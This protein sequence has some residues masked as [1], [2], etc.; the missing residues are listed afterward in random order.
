[1]ESLEDHKSQKVRKSLEVFKSQRRLPGL[2][3]LE[4]QDS[5]RL[6]DHKSQ[7]SGE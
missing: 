2:K 5:G 7:E 6:A 3:K 4:P 1:M